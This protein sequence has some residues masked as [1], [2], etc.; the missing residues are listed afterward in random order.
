VLP[1]TIIPA[2]QRVAQPSQPSLSFAAG[3][4]ANAHLRFMGIGAAMEVSFDG[5]STWQAAQLQAQAK[6]K[7]DSF[8]SYWM[9]VPAGVQQVQFRSQGWYG[10][11]WRVRDASLWAPP[12]S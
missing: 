6:Q 1:F 9:P 11:P 3:A 10:G 8:L 12:A 5:G 2:T 7:G 4:P